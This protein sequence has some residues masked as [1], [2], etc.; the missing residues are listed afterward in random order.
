MYDIEYRKIQEA[1]ANLLNVKD[2]IAKGAY[3]LFKAYTEAGFTEEQAIKL[4]ISCLFPNQ[5]DRR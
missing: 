1:I 5:Q 4:V 2:E 3:G